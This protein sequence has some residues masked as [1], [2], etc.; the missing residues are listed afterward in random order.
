MEQTWKQYRRRGMTE[1][2]PYVPGEDLQGISVS[3]TDTPALGGMIARNPENHQDQW[4]VNAAYV[5]ANMEECPQP[6]EARTDR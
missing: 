1:M 2:R 5:A 6:Q 4:Y 3:G